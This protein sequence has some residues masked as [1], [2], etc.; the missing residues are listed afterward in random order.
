MHYENAKRFEELANRQR[1]YVLDDEQKRKLYN[2]YVFE[3]KIIEDQENMA[4]DEMIRINEISK[5]RSFTKLQ[6]RLLQDFYNNYSKL[7]DDLSEQ[8]ESLNT[9]EE[10]IYDKLL[11]T[12]N[13]IKMN[14]HLTQGK[15]MSEQIPGL[16]KLILTSRKGE[17]HNKP[18]LIKKF[19]YN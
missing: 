10:L 17:L 9:E 15:K 12:K 8:K 13:Q 2:D 16:K 4:K 19:Q 11:E 3:R 5:I 1:K 7:L 14:L 6:Q 18:I